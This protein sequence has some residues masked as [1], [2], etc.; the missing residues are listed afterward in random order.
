MVGSMTAGRNPDPVK[1]GNVIAFVKPSATRRYK[2]VWFGRSSIIHV[3]V[4][5]DA[6][7][8]E[9]CTEQAPGELRWFPFTPSNAERE[10]WLSHDP[11]PTAST[12][13][14]CAASQG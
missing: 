8:H 5:V 14:A 9:D 10:I 11:L 6:D 12:L 4:D 7:G 13:S 1:R 3:I 2:Y